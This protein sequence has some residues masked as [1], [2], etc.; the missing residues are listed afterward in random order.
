MFVHV[1]CLHSGI[2]ALLCLIHALGFW[3]HAAGAVQRQQVFRHHCKHVY[4]CWWHTRE[5]NTIISTKVMI[6]LHITVRFAIICTDIKSLRF[7]GLNKSDHKR[8]IRTVNVFK[9]LLI[10]T[11]M[12]KSIWWTFFSSNPFCTSFR[13]WRPC[14]WTSTRCT[15]ATWSYLESVW[16]SWCSISCP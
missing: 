7:I 14:T 16:A 13:W 12:D 6:C 11:L 1:F 2:M 4:Q 15:L 10:L 9:D 3:G 5:L 8:F